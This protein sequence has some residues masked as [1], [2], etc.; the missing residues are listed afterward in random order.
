MTVYANYLTNPSFETNTTSWASSDGAT[1]TRGTT[2]KQIGSY[3][4]QLSVST[5]STQTKGMETTV[6]IDP[7][8]APL[9]LSGYLIT[10]AAANGATYNRLIVTVYDM[11]P[12]ETNAQRQQVGTLTVTATGRWA[13]RNLT[14]RAGAN[15]LVARLAMGNTYFKA[16]EW[17]QTGP[18][19][20]R[21]YG[22]DYP[23]YESHW[24][25]TT[26]FANS[27]YN[28]TING[29]GSVGP[30]G[31]GTGYYEVTYYELTWSPEV[32]GGTANGWLD[33]LQLERG[34]V[35]TAYVDGDSPGHVWSGTP[36]A[37]AT[38]G[39]A[40]AQASGTANSTGSL[41]TFTVLLPTL[42]GTA[43]ST[44]S[45][46]GDLVGMEAKGTASST[47]KLAL[48]PYGPM[49][50]SG[51]ADSVGSLDAYPVIYI[52]A[53]GDG[54]SDGGLMLDITYPISL[55]GTGSSTGSAEL[56]FPPELQASGTSSSTG[57]LT[58]A[59]AG[60][61]AGH[62]IGSSSG[63]LDL[64]QAIPPGAFA[65]FAVFG[66]TETDPLLSVR[67]RSN[68][69]TNTGANGAEW[70]RIYCDFVA[71]EDVTTSDGTLWKRAA[72]VVPGI[73][74]DNVAATN[75]Q[76]FTMYQ[77]QVSGPNGPTLY[78]MA[79]S[80]VP[81]VYPDRLNIAAT[82]LRISADGVE[83]SSFDVPSPFPDDTQS[84]QWVVCPLDVQQQ[85]FTSYDILRGN[86]WYTVSAYIYKSEGMD[87]LHL[88]VYNPATGAQLGKTASY[89]DGIDAPEAGEGWKR[90]VTVFQAPADGG[91]RMLWEPQITQP[92]IG[93]EDFLV[94]G[95]L[96]EEG[97]AM[98]PYFFW[99][100]GNIDLW[101]RYG[102]TDASGGTFHYK[103]FARRSY[104]LKQAL[105]E[106]APTG[107]IVE[108]PE[109]GK[110]PYLDN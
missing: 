7:G 98:E 67:A 33:A 83:S 20:R 68:G 46:D 77:V 27:K 85:I 82:D 94:A 70:V 96:L 74:F 57:D 106:S 3:G 45:L 63:S 75:W 93:D 59:I 92:Q 81:Y 100:E 48:W 41:D 17:V 11:L 54:T 79:N 56:T 24:S 60:Q 108:F 88:K 4:L 102:Y 38:L 25:A 29:Y 61:T 14:P 44:G 50:A 110:I 87:D 95:H 2:Q 43:S 5:T 86:A 109:F 66:V 39:I 28:S 15:R 51:S 97:I 47:G 55:S 73:R 40:Y 71:P 72:Y 21:F 84:A 32:N 31:D 76:Q 80:L 89:A 22:S 19:Y 18:Y 104:I 16:G 53:V 58:A 35:E 78:R 23:D 8:T 69:G 36:H 91:V 12:E 1:L 62:G 101:R 64:G 26:S 107:V 10:R 99:K 6:A 42:A 52:G 9:T 34:S 90:I 49:G 105:D 30:S 13:L 37:S 103:D 65:D